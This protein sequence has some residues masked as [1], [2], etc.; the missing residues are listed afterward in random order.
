[1]TKLSKSLFPFIYKQKVQTG[2]MRNKLDANAILL[3]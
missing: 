2:A 3:I 1:L